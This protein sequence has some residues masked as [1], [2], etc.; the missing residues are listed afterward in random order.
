MP[1][2]AARLI[3]VP[4]GEPAALRLWLPIYAPGLQEIRSPRPLKLIFS[5]ISLKPHGARAPARTG[6]EA[7]AF[8]RGS[9]LG[10]Y[11]NRHNA[12]AARTVEQGMLF[13]FERAHLP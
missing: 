3:L 11:V 1:Q 4:A 5:C 9:P 6:L 10:L 7:E 2:S 12:S 8:C 13:E